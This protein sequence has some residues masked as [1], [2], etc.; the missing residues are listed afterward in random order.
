VLA[1][2]AADTQALGRLRNSSETLAV[3]WGAIESTRDPKRRAE[4]IQRHGEA[5]TLAANTLR[6]DCETFGLNGGYS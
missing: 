5:L 1:N 2:A 3:I 4:L 6:S